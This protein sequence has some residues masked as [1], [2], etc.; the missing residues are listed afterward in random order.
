MILLLFVAP[1]VTSL[2]IYNG[3]E[4][5]GESAEFVVLQ[6]NID[7]YNDKYGSLTQLQQD[8]ILLSLAQNVVTKETS[9]V[10]APE[11]FTSGIVENYPESDASLN[12][13]KEFIAA[14]PSS[15]FLLEQLQ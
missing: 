8:S 2:I 13:L 3:Y 12:R 6:P 14:Y 7:P 11:T 9:V 4:E 5:E 10:I 1:V 15:S